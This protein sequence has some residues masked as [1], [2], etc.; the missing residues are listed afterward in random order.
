[1][2]YGYLIC[3]AVQ[4]GKGDFVVLVAYEVW[5]MGGLK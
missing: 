5:S 2:A 4:N 3:K 1:M